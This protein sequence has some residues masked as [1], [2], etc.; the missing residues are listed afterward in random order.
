MVAK[1]L[2]IRSE[3]EIRVRKR[4]SIRIKQAILG[5]GKVLI[6]QN[7]DDRVSS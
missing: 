2:G 3:K 6:A 7:V 4:I 5:N 1:K